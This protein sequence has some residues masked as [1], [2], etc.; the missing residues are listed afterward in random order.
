MSADA[1]FTVVETACA[2][3]EAAAHAEGGARREA[4]GARCDMEGAPML[5]WYRR[6]RGASAAPAD[7][8]GEA[9]EEQSEQ[10]KPQSCCAAAK[11][12]HSVGDGGE[13]SKA[14]D[15]GGE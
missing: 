4:M 3:E 12:D 2:R 7:R 13:R 6:H 8:Y 11:G 1:I 14:D 9:V 10:Q 15:G 5:T